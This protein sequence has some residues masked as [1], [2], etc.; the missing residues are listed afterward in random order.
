MPPGAVTTTGPV[1]APV[2]TVAVI[3]V[4][5]TTV[6]LAD[7]P[8]KVT[9]VVPVRLFPRMITDEPTWPE[10]VTVWTKGPSPVDSLKAVP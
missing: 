7:V 1:V 10:A 8:L 9:L 3:S 2:G 4:P 6:K 5:D